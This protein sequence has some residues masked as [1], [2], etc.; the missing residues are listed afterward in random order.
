[1]VPCVA[2]IR[3]ADGG[4]RLHQGIV[5][6][7]NTYDPQWAAALLRRAQGPVRSYIGQAV[8]PD[9][10]EG[11][12]MMNDHDFG[13][14]VMNRRDFLRLGL[15]AVGPLVVP[16]AVLGRNAAVAP[17]DRI[18]LG[19]I[20]GGGRGMNDLR[21]FLKEKDVRCLAVCDCW[22][23]RRTR[24]KAMVDAHYGNQDCVAHRFHEEVLERDDID[25]VLIVTGDRWHAVL[26]SLAA[27]AG[28]DAYCEKPFTLTIAEGQ[29][30]VETANRYGTVWQCGTQRR[31]ND[32]FRFVVEVIHQG[33][34]GQLRTITTSF[35]G[36]GG[37]GFARPEPAPRGFD[38]DR[39][40]GQAPRAP[41][42][43]VRVNLWRNNWDTG[44]GV[45]PDM[46]AHYFDF[47]QWAHDSELSG[48][49]EFE[50]EGEFP[51]DGF[52]NVPFRI[53]VEARYADGVRIVMDS[54]AKAVRFEGDDGWIH[55]TDEGEITA[56]PES[57]LKGL[58][59]PV[60]HW[61]YMAGHI[62]NFLECIRSRKL[63]ASPP[64]IA[65]RAHTVAHC[66]NI[67]LRL[68]R[69]VRWNPE[70]ERFVDDDDANKML[71]RTM[72]AP[73]RV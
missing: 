28:K 34:I 42:S 6:L 63:T 41:Y 19:A 61:S 32:A 17:S 65:H 47:A 54:G 70:A 8:M 62:R 66:A 24:M 67:C 53:N 56:R 20:G 9:T 31:S 11:E 43:S 60:V 50:G 49:V 15:A 37:N 5:F 10:T 51:D 73:W 72:R 23:N 35:G 1:M 68:G 30:F 18:A 21:D 48:P 16:A 3:V 64:E 52:T 2:R 13:R 55:I 45:I 22:A 58:E 33:R 40:L 36:W 57:V 44:G 29:S 7:A 25:A 26:S 71:S 59:P 4:S 27:R 38:Y 69:R 39:W 46:G 14:Q 12:R